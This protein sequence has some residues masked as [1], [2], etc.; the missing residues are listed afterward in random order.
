M[1]V[2]GL[3][4]IA[5]ATQV[6]CESLQGASRQQQPDSDASLRREGEW[7]AMG[8]EAGGEGEKRGRGGGGSGD[9]DGKVE[10]ACRGRGKAAQ[11]KWEEASRLSRI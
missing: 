4:R 6:R 10:A 11:V 7:S 9:G 2:P 8:E 3:T 1:Q 5:P